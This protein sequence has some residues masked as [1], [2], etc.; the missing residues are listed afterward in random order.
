[1]KR[2]IVVRLIVFPL[3]I[4][5][6][7]ILHF[8]RQGLTTSRTTLSELPKPIQW[9]TSKVK[10]NIWNVDSSANDE[11]NHCQDAK[12]CKCSNH[13]NNFLFLYFQIRYYHCWNF[14]LLRFDDFSHSSQKF[15]FTFPFRLKNFLTPAIK[16]KRF[17]VYSLISNYQII[18][19]I[20]SSGLWYFS[21][22]WWLRCQINSCMLSEK[23]EKAEKQRKNNSLF[24]DQ[25]SDHQVS[26]VDWEQD[27]R[28]YTRQI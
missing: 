2:L 25:W 1:M 28:R 20:L 5:H 12:Q 18:F 14:D 3:A 24:S 6:T 16:L 7:H 27:S 13:I 19:Y 15:V 10:D 17:L 4:L 9:T 23:V 21:I 22:V 11:A 26:S 8:N